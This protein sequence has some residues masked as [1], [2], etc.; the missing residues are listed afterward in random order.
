MK[1]LICTKLKQSLFVRFELGDHCW[2]SEYPADALQ[3][4]KSSWN[5]EHDTPQHI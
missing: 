3:V 2:L 4:A 1:L 5:I